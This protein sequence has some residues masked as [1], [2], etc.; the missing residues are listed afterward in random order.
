MLKDNAKIVVSEWAD[1]SGNV[2]TN[3]DNEHTIINKATYTVQV[4]AEYGD[5]EEAE[6]TTITYCPGYD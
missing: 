4:R 1:H 5:I 6:T 3:P 2:V